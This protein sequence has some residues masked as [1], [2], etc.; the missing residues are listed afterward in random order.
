MSVMWNDIDLYHAVRDFTA[1]PVSFPPDEVRS[2]I[3]ELVST[4]VTHTSLAHF[5]TSFRPKIIS[6]MCR[7]WTQL[8]P[9]RRTQRIWCVPV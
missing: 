6:T 7:F 9:N 5:D 1:D 4:F 2:F 3:R 8:F